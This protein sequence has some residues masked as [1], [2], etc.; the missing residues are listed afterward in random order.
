MEYSDVL[1]SKR[2]K[3]S[4]VWRRRGWMRRSGRKRE[5][6]GWERDEEFLGRAGRRIRAW[7]DGEMERA[8]RVG[9]DDK[10]EAEKARVAARKEGGE[11]FERL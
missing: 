6:E 1:E 8:E 3:P 2:G 9:K 11:T 4:D 7:V 5:G 10:G